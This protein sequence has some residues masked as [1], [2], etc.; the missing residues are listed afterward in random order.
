MSCTSKWRSPRV[1]REASRT[2][3]NASAMSDSSDSPSWHALAE[4]RGE[5]PELVVRQLL[6]DALEPAREAGDSSELAQLAALAH[7]H[8]PVN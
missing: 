3:A 4:L 2:A 1:R 8:H 5:R 6:V 7:P